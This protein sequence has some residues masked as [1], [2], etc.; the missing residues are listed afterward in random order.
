MSNR[1]T[2]AAKPAIHH[3]DCG[4]SF[5]SRSG[6]ANHSHACP[7]ERARSAAFVDA[8]EN[9]GNPHAAGAAA[10]TRALALRALECPDLTA[11]ERARYRA[12]A[13]AV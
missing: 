5:T 11:A 4:R 13:T 7:V 12:Q 6:L 8:L 10:V 9:G 1:R 2:A 3:C